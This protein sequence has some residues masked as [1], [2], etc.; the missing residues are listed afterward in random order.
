MLAVFDSSEELDNND[1]DIL[2]LIDKENT[3]VILNKTDKEKMVDENCFEGFKTVFISAKEGE[4]EEE[5][6]KAVREIT[7]ADAI[8]P[9]AALLLSER[10]RDLVSKARDSVAEA[11]N[12]LK[13]GFTVD[14]IEVCV[15]EALSTLYTLSGKRVTNEVADEVFRRFCVGK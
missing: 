7:A 15:E 12:M 13:C 6:E 1:K 5:L 9:A 10:Q 11:E 2:S 8:N 3:I 14:A 4:G